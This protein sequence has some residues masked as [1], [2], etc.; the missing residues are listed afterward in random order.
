VSG[1]SLA[2]ADRVA[3]LTFD[4]PSALN[5]LDTATR[6]A[7]V[8]ALTDFANDPDIAAVVFTGAGERGYC[9]GQDVKE[10]AALGRGDGLKWMES[11]KAYFRAVSAFPKPI[12][13]AVNGVAAGA[14]FETVLM[15]DIRLAVPKARFIMAEV[16]IGLPAIVGGHLL[17]THLGFSRMTELVLSGRTV[18]AEEARHIGLVHEIVP[19]KRLM[20]R[21]HAVAAEIA[22]KPPVALALNLREFRRQFRIGLAEA[23]NASAAY[24]DEAVATGEPQAAMAR[25]LD[26]RRGNAAQHSAVNA[27]RQRNDFMTKFIKVAQDDDV[28]II[29]LNRP[30]VLNAWHSPMRVEITGAME[31]LNADPSVRA[32][33]ITGAGD[34]A[35]CAGQ[36]LNETKTFDAARAADWIEEWR[37]MYG[38]IRALD[39]PLVAALNGVAA[40]SAFQ[41]ALLADVRIGHSGVRMGQPEIN[42]AIA[43]TLGPWLM[44]E[45]LGLSR[46]IELTL[47]GR[48]M[49]AA[50]CHHIGLI[51]KLV[52]KRDVMK[53]AKETA[54][55]LAAKPPVA[56]RLDKRRFREVTEAGFNE[57]LD[58][59]IRIQKESYGSGEPQRFMEKF[60]AE[61]ANKKKKT[62]ARAV[63]KKK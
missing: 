58:S 11:W 35:F 4:R 63:R 44:R 37:R 60:L 22:A 12:V 38:A 10:S 18:D 32:I 26:R 43:S 17:R 62:S 48:M 47:S 16:D 57:A 36:D 46:T 40:G 45:M 6:L 56:M 2:R 53:A 5:A 9:A 42:S 13:H 51:H 15:G 50:E 55:M 1:L 52:S 61:R 54:R 34:R 19:P 33:I 31:K 25:F 23:A 8:A 3:T 39:K 28:A 41:V 49:N 30:E 14:G 21:A 20:A 24:Q 59:G 29:T 27:P 7:V